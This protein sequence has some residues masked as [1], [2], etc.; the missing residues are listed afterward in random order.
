MKKVN[1]EELIAHL[2]KE[3]A[4]IGKQGK[5][6]SGFLDAILA[7]RKFVYPRPHACEF[8]NNGWQERKEDDDTAQ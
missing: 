1:A 2:E 7:V 8:R 5:Q 4:K 6:R 3:C